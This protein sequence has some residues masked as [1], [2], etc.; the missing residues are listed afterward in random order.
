MANDRTSRE[1]L[2]RLTHP[3]HDHTTV[4]N[5]ERDRQSTAEKLDLTTRHKVLGVQDQKMKLLKTTG[6]AQTLMEIQDT[7]TGE[8]KIGRT[9]AE[10]EG[11]GADSNM[12]YF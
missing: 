5:R 2:T 4:V 6:G 10:R 7:S 1:V 12:S 3:Y 8:M 9:G 11:I